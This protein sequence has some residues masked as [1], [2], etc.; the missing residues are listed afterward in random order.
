[1][2][3]TEN[4]RKRIF[5]NDNNKDDFSVRFIDSRTNQVVTISD[6]SE[7]K[8]RGIIK[9][10]IKVGSNPPKHITMGTLRN[11]EKLQKQYIK[12]KFKTIVE[13]GKLDDLK[14]GVYNHIG[15]F[16][17]VTRIEKSQKLF[18]KTP[19]KVSYL[20]LGDPKMDNVRYVKE[21]LDP[22]LE[23]E[24]KRFE[25]EEKIRK[26]L[27]E[28]RE[29]QQNRLPDKSRKQFVK[30]MQADVPE[31]TQISKIE[32]NNDTITNW[33]DE[34]AEGFKGS[35][36]VSKV[37]EEVQRKRIER[38]ENPI[39][40]KTA[41]DSYL[42]DSNQLVTWTNYIGTDLSTGKI[43]ELKNCIQSIVNDKYIYTGNLN[44]TD[45]TRE[46][47]LGYMVIFELPFS[48]DRAIKEGN[49]EPV[50][51]LLSED[52]QAPKLSFDTMTFL[53]AVTEDMNVQRA[54]PTSIILRNRINQSIKAYEGIIKERKNN[55]SKTK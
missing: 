4:K 18:K 35:L 1:M 33:R 31:N 32:D 21:F 37:V 34:N 5:L 44:R 48:I 50:L 10:L 52:K 19:Q 6:F 49:I 2:N 25:E 22:E 3:E 16:T 54:M 29:K 51:K 28:C 17:T 55:N 26:Y 15:D 46:K 36:S 12:E 13:K 23:E 41:T 11:Q 39:L 45:V 47:E 38:I 9:A 27:Q 43:I 42:N 30:D 40:D 7:I 8:G 24:R 20:T 53:G 14:D